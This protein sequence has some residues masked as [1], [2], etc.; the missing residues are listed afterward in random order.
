MPPR[1]WKFVKTAARYPLYPLFVNFYFVIDVYQRNLFQVL[2]ADTLDYLFLSTAVL[3]LLVAAAHALPRRFAAVISATLFFAYLYLALPDFILFQFDGGPK[4]LPHLIWTALFLYVSMLVVVRGGRFAGRF[5]VAYNAIAL[6]AVLWSMGGLVTDILLRQPGDLNLAEIQIGASG[7]TAPVRPN[8][9][10]IVLDGYARHDVMLR[11]YGFD[12]SKFLHAL[13]GRGFKIAQRATAPYNQTHLSLAATFQGGYFDAER[14]AGLNDSNARLRRRL[15]NKITMGPVHKVLRRQ[16]YKFFATPIGLTGFYGH[17]GDTTVLDA[18]A[19]GE[20][21]T[22]EHTLFTK[23]TVNRIAPL[24]SWIAWNN[25]R[26]MNRDLRFSFD[27][28]GFRGPIAGALESGAPIH[29]YQHALAPHPPFTITAE[30][31]DTQAWL[32]YT[33]F[34]ATGNAVIHGNPERR[35]HY[36]AGYLEKLKYTNRT[37]LAYIDQITAAIPEPRVIILQSDHGGSVFYNHDELKYSCAGE[38]YGILFA[39]QTRP[40]VPIIGDEAA[41]AYNAVNIYRDIFAAYFN[42]PTPPLP[43][44]SFFASWN[45]LRNFEPVD[46]SQPKSCT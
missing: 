1:A 29:L 6:L 8:I 17:P 18:Y 3:G 26:Q 2:F 7:G 46:L 11:E 20:R 38:R 4:L 22:F 28:D 27:F 21:W 45:N 16:G 35:K 19:Q 40:Q 30:G 32:P 34:I 10:H 13:R 15:S 41:T 14:L 23:R 44:R 33:E 24:G 37:L 9:V 31:G 43:S 39:I 12:N 5:H 25:L 42:L 36:L